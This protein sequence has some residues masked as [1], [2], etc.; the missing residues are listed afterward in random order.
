MQT[1]NRHLPPQSPIY[2]LPNRSFALRPSTIFLRR[3]WHLPLAKGRGEGRNG[4]C[5]GGANSRRTFGPWGRKREPGVAMN[6]Y[7]FDG[8]NPGRTQKEGIIIARSAVVL[9]FCSILFPPLGP[10]T[11][12]QMDAE[13]SGTSSL[14]LTGGGGGPNAKRRILINNRKPRQKKEERRKIARFNE[15]PKEN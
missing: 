15:P 8:S 13:C 14:G 11:L 10:F 7:F 6:I 2:L 3:N 4:K 9:S 1:K 5:A 12:R